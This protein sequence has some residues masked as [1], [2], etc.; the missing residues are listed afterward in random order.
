MMFSSSFDDLIVGAPLYTVRKD[1]RIIAD[2][3]RVDVFFQTA[4]VRLSLLFENGSNT[5]R[6][7]FVAQI[8]SKTIDRRKTGEWTFWTR[9]YQPW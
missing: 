5:F 6:L 3:G 8:D 1:A 7:N 9:Y 2:A 4:Q